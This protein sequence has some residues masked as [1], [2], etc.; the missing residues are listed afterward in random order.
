MGAGWGGGG[1]GRRWLPA[2]LMIEGLAGLCRNSVLLSKNADV[3][4]VIV[5]TLSGVT[6]TPWMYQLRVKQLFPLNICRWCC[7]LAF[8]HFW[9]YSQSSIYLTLYLGRPKFIKYFL[10]LQLM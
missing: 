6:H 5:L 10:K 2:S 3:F 1:G 4:T 7:S 8:S 9:N